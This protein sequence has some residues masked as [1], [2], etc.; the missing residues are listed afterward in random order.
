MSDHAESTI[1]APGL[2]QGERR[3]SDRNDRCAG[4]EHAG[5]RV[6]KSMPTFAAEIVGQ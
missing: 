1:R 6:E 2:P 4:L 3:S 5:V